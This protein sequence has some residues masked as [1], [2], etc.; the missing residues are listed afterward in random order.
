E[1]IASS[2]WA[3]RVSPAQRKIRAPFCPRDV[4]ARASGALPPRDEHGAED[5]E[6]VHERDGLPCL[7]DQRRGLLAIQPPP[8]AKRHHQIRRVRIPRASQRL[9]PQVELP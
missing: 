8:P 2:R 5:A 4:P 1:K 3:C 6:R 9:E 7:R